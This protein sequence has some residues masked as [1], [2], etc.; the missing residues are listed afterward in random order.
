[1]TQVFNAKKAIQRRKISPQSVLLN[2]QPV[3]ALKVLET[4]NLTSSTYILRLERK[5]LGFTSGQHI[6]LGEVETGD[7][8]EYS[9]YSGVYD[10]FFE[11][12]IK[13]VEDG[14]VSKRLRKLQPGEYVS[15]DGPFGFFRINEDLIKTKKHLF[16]ASGTGLAPFHSFIKSYPELDYTVLHGV[17][18]ANETYEC[19]EYPESRYIACTSRDKTG[20]YHGRVTAY[21]KDNM[22][23][24]DTEI[25]LCGNSAMIHNAYDILIDHG[26]SSDHIHSEVYF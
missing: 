13:E 9:V 25:Y 24:K 14:L 6:S 5:G 18:Y 3:K 17:R 19:S 11:V 10:D 16:I 23:A 21:L 15:F 20:N 4:R 12:L 26:F 2:Y 8:R 7:K 22:P 1:M